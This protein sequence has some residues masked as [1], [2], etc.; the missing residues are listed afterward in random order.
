MVPK[1]TPGEYRLIHHLSFPKRSSIND[2]I[3]DKFSSVQYASIRDAI[4]KI[5]MASKQ[6]YLA[7]ADVKS[8]FC[9]IP[10][11]PAGYH[12]LGMEWQGFYYLVHVRPL[13][14]L[15]PL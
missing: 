6:C 15:V 7:K 8:A 13:N 12:L 3:S 1:K 5:K 14:W 10:V 11:S 4:E 9:I 2:G